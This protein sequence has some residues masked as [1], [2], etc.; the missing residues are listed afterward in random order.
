MTRI[1]D[2]ILEED[3]PE[4]HYDFGFTF[5]PKSGDPET[6]EMYKVRM[7]SMR[8]SK[9]KAMLLGE[10]NDKKHYASRVFAYLINGDYHVP[11][12]PGQQPQDTTIDARQNTAL[13]YAIDPCIG[14]PISNH[15]LV[16]ALYSGFLAEVIDTH[17]N[18]HL[19]NL[20]GATALD[21]IHDIDL[22]TII[23]YNTKT[24]RPEIY[25]VQ[26]FADAYT[27][28]QGG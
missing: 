4:D 11:K 9:I 7:E 21:L 27:R 28:I 22:V 16:K 1:F 26:A 6:H 2:E 13:H 24:F 23:D 10:Y 25:D 14:G 12:Y 15:H 18:P 19:A 3:L 5:L 17:P 20:H 8:R